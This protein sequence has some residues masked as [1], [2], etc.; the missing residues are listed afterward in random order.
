MN[1]SKPGHFC[2]NLGTTIKKSLFNLTFQFKGWKMTRN[3]LK[4]FQFSKMNF[5]WIFR[6]L[7]NF[8]YPS[9]VRAVFSV[10]WH[11]WFRMLDLT[12]KY[13]FGTSKI[14]NGLSTLW[15]GFIKL[16]YR[17]MIGNRKLGCEQLVAKSCD[18]KLN[19]PYHVTF[20]LF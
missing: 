20:E 14:L 8:E 3:W 7:M 11:L 12:K 5:S 19:W 18:Q 15:I 10:S 4:K 6:F 17:S 1:F 9:L 2:G 13:S 16:A